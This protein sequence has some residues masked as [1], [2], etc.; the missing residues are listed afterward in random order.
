MASHG[1]ARPR[2][3]APDSSWFATGCRSP[4]LPT[5]WAKVL[6]EVTPTAIDTTI[7]RYLGGYPLSMRD[8]VARL[9]VANKLAPYLARK[10]PQRHALQ[11]DAALYDYTL[12]LQQNYLRSQ[13][14]L[15]KLIWQNKL[16]GMPKVQGLPPAGSR[17]QGARP[18][19]KEIG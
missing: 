12:E 11:S 19:E 17:G 14:P 9:I 6:A 13:S 8:D 7:A 3:F 10:Y 1:I 16:D 5:R 15:Q 18:T 4:S 2:R